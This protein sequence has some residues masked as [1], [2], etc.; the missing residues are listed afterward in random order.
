MYVGDKLL[1]LIV[2]IPKSE[3]ILFWEPVMICDSSF[4]ERLDNVLSKRMSP[5]LFWNK[6]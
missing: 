2:L 3:N 5:L 6:S 1:Q 4:F